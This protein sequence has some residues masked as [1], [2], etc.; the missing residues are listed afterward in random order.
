MYPLAGLGG[1]GKGGSG[2]EAGRYSATVGIQAGCSYA[3]RLKSNLLP[4]IHV[5]S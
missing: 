5:K 2:G 1:E 3:G 4:P